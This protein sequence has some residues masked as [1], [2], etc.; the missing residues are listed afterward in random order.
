M[1][2]RTDIKM[3]P[4]EEK[5]TCVMTVV[6]ASAKRVQINL[7]NP[8]LHYAMLFV[9]RGVVLHFFRLFI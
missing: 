4:T 5:S 6:V 1:L 7:L 3:K 8:P 9:C 2:L